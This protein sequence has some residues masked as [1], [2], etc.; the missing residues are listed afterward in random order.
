[1]IHLSSFIQTMSL[2]AN[3]WGGPRYRTEE[4]AKFLNKHLYNIQ[5]E[6][7]LAKERVNAKLSHDAFLSS[8]HT[9]LYLSSIKDVGVK[10]TF[11]VTDELGYE[12][13][14]P[15]GTEILV[16]EENVIKWKKIEKLKIGDQR[17]INFE[18]VPGL[19]N[20]GAHHH[21]KFSDNF[22]SIKCKDVY[23]SQAM[24]CDG[25]AGMSLLKET[26]DTVVHLD[27]FSKKN[28][29]ELYFI[30]IVEI[31]QS[32]P[33]TFYELEFLQFSYSLQKN[34]QLSNKSK[35]R[36]YKYRK[37]TMGKRL[38]EKLRS[39]VFHIKKDKTEFKMELKHDKDRD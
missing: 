39:K 9:P 20:E 22:L 8:R 38:L 28:I 17:V 3:R 12:G 15:E 19:K 26:N 36:Y 33:I 6:Q 1:M 4:F 24:L 35:N 7:L 10:N 21:L 25:I 5:E 37:S 32:S 14:F 29:Q 2:Y 11:I 18:L 30:D 23:E 31:L 16:N 13:V 27:Q 34:R